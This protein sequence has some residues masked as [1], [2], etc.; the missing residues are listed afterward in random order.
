MMLQMIA[1]RN[2]SVW[3]TDWL[4]E[5]VTQREQVRLSIKSDRYRFCVGYKS[6][7]AGRQ[8]LIPQRLLTIRI[9]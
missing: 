2:T 4:S 5:L 7:T 3:C 6:L 8:Q 1:A 9:F